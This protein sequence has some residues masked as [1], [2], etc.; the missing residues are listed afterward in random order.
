MGHLVEYSISTSKPEEFVDITH[1]VERAVR[2]SGIRNGVA[3]VFCPHTTAGITINENADPDVVHDI[4]KALD[5]AFPVRGDYRHVEGNS[6]AHIKAS[7]MGS[8][9]HIIISEGRLVLGTWQGVYFCEF[10]GPRRRKVYISCME[11]K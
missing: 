11:A 9:C 2:D 1:L 7:C 5:K 10:D 3:V 4:I 8:S 6:H